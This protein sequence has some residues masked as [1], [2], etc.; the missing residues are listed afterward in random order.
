MFLPPTLNRLLSVFQCTAPA[1]IIVLSSAQRRSSAAARCPMCLSTLCST[2]RCN[3]VLGASCTQSVYDFANANTSE[4]KKDSN[5]DLYK[6][7]NQAFKSR[8]WVFT[9]NLYPSHPHSKLC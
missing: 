1:A 3:R 4:Q 5:C 8:G 6:T 9:S 7:K 2:V